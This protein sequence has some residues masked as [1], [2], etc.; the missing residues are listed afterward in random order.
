MSHYFVGGIWQHLSINSDDRGG[1]LLHGNHI[2]DVVG[3][4]TPR[5][6]LRYK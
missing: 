3:R 1:G 6:P 5:Q 2:D 4:I